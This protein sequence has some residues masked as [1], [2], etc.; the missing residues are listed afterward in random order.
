[1]HNKHFKKGL[2]PLMYEKSVY[3]LRNRYKGILVCN[4]TQTL[5][6]FLTEKGFMKG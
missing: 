5:A 4:G 1:M 3:E 6:Q 2:M